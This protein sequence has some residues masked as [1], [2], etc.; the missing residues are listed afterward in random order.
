[1]INI[2]GLPS[3]L[4]CN[5]HGCE[6]APANIRQSGLFNAL[7]SCGLSYEDCGDIEIDNFFD[8]KIKPKNLY[9]FL[10][11]TERSLNK[12]LTLT[13]KQDINLYLGGD[14]SV[15]VSTVLADRMI[16]DDLFVLWIDD[17]ADVNSPESSPTGNIHGMPLSTIA[18][19]SLYKYFD[20]YP[21]VKKENIIIL[22]AKDVDDAEW[23]YIRK[24]NISI[25]TIDD[26]VERGIGDI[27]TE[28]N[29]K[30]NNKPLHVSLDIDCL[31]WEIAPGTGIINNGG[32]NYR[33][34]SFLARKISKQN[35]V[36]IDIAEIN[37]D[38]DKQS[39]TLDLSVEIIAD[40]FGGKWTEYERY[41][42]N[43]KKTLSKNA[44]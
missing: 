19:D 32:M 26:I 42:S 10:E 34:I 12:I 1:M 5:K 27:W 14:H 11:L 24:N 31:D 44:Y 36:G 4:G 43:E 16:Y 41:L 20:K 29:D 25:Y 28:I 22:G 39:K 6:K 18:G 15:A 17:H 40:M 35:V 9:K 13:K 7:N 8:N 30:I 3:I 38:C 21:F 33:E 23:D 2:F 37:P